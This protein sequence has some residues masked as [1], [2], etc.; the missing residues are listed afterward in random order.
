MSFHTEVLVRNLG[1]YGGEYDSSATVVAEEQA[2]GQA[3]REAQA[4]YWISMFKKF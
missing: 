1:D 4:W 3:S 2:C